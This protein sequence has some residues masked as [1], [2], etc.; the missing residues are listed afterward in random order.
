ME[1]GSVVLNGRVAVID[2]G[3]KK[4]KMRGRRAGEERKRGMLR[5][6]T[7]GRLPAFIVAGRGGN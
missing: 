2:Q 6:E 7:G 3:K 4:T 5:A 1:K